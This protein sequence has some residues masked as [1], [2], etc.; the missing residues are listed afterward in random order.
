VVP[1]ETAYAV[2]DGPIPVFQEF[3]TNG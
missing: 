1:T 2:T 3:P